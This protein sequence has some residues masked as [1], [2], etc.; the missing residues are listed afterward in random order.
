M[1]GQDTADRMR[2]S[3]ETAEALVGERLDRINDLPSVEARNDAVT[4]L[5]MG[6]STALA[7][8]ATMYLRHTS[9]QPKSFGKQ[10]GKHVTTVM[11]GMRHVL[12]EKGFVNDETNV[13]R[14]ANDPWE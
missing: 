13:A 6:L 11:E 5:I 7:L 9:E 3:N 10:V 4:D 2:R 14:E 1:K 8:V 12:M